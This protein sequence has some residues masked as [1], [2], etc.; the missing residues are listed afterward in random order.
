MNY[1]PVLPNRGNTKSLELKVRLVEVTDAHDGQRIDN[2]LIRLCKGVPKSHIYK[3][4]RA[5]EVRVN[6]GRCQVDYRLEV[7]DLV[8]VPPFRLPV[9]N[10]RIVPPR[11]FEV[12]FEDDDLLIINKPEGV[13]VHGGSG[14]SHGVIESLRAANPAMPFL[15][16]VHRLDRET[17]G[18]L[19]LAKR[20]KALV[21]LHEMIRS[22]KINKEYLALVTGR[23]A[24]DRQHIKASLTKW[25]TA[26][27][28]R[29]VRVDPDGQMAHTIV[30][31]VQRYEVASLVRAELR[32]GRTHQIRVHLASLGH[33]IVGD[34]KYASDALC[35]QWRSLSIRRMM[36]HASDLKFEHPM[37][38]QRVELALPLPSAFGLA[39]QAV[40]A[41]V[42]RSN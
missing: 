37:T 30:T 5:G 23:I 19:M 24:N 28:E 9:Q 14:V 31:C 36:L 38:G 25:L 35:S 11:T 42:T 33:A 40:D 22:G 34:E 13:A 10:Q 32:T 4:V 39:A 27:G 6:K 1:M 21:R 41:A 3:A 2:F 29:R 18:L 17:S 7:G 15:E 20:R 26:T 8:R 12:V 16:L